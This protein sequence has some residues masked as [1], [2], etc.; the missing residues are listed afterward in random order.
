MNISICGA[1]GFVGTRLREYL[2][3]SGHKVVEINRSTL[4]YSQALREIVNTSHVVINLAGAT[5]SK[6]WTS[7]YKKEILDSRINS[8][9]AIVDAIN[10]STH[11]LTFICASAVGIYND[12]GMHN[13]DSTD[14]GDSFLAQ[15]CVKWETE[16]QRVRDGV[17][18]VITRF[19]V[20]LA[21]NGGVIKQ[22]L[23]MIRRGFGVIFGS[24]KVPLSWIGREDLM[25]AIRFII[26]NPRL[27]GIINLTA[28]ECSS[29]LEFTTQL[30][31][32]YYSRMPVV[33]LPP[34]LPKL[35]LGERSQLIL[36]GQCAVPRRLVE[37]GFQFRT[38]KLDQY[39]ANNAKI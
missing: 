32:S 28:P 35:I 19:G 17:R 4:E 9:K 7:R 18:G 13:E 2:A 11:P 31:H 34:F 12:E 14:Y 20:V 33:Y 27:R 1:S 30:L 37:A 15:V 5:I 10:S 26:E 8:T 16:A 24:G 22:L 3:D 36:R 29:Q 38:P 25:R 6:R 23:P 39:F 21:P